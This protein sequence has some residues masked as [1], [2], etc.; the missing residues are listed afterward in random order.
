[1]AKKHSPKAK[2]RGKWVLT[3]GL[4]GMG[5]ASTSCCYHGRFSMIAVE[6]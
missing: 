2:Q 1:M 3:G 4:G 6:V 5:G